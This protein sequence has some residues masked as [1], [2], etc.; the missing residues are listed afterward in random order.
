M[1]KISITCIHKTHTMY[2]QNKYNV[3]DTKFNETESCIRI[4]AH[5]LVECRMDDFSAISE[6]RLV[7]QTLVLLLLLELNS[8]CLP[9]RQLLLG[10]PSLIPPSEN[11]QRR[12]GKRG[13][14]FQVDKH[15]PY[16]LQDL[17]NWIQCLLNRIARIH[18]CRYLVLQHWRVLLLAFEMFPVGWE[19]WELE[20]S[21][22]P[23]NLVFGTATKTKLPVEFP[24]S[25]L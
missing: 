5:F 13:Y 17:P 23:K 18:S 25:W 20:V 10:W 16:P 4:Q 11:R 15:C 9:H 14:L 22:C 19:L 7:A 21:D 6:F 1:K 24:G 3:S 12:M 2:T 8:P